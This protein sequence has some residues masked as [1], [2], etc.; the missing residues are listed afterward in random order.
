MASFLTVNFNSSFFIENLL[1]SIP[2]TWKES[3]EI[4]IVDNSRNLSLKNY[5]DLKIIEGTGTT[6]FE[7]IE[8][9]IKESSNE[10]IIFSDS[11]CILLDCNLL[12]QLENFLEK[13]V[14]MIQCEGNQFKP[15]H[16]CF[17]CLKKSV[18]EE[19]K[20]S[21]MSKG[22]KKEPEDWKKIFSNFKKNNLNNEFK[23]KVYFDVGVECAYKLLRN[24][25]KVLSIP[26]ICPS[27]E[28]YEFF[29]NKK[30]SFSNLGW[31]FGFEKPQVWHIVYGSSKKRYLKKNSEEIWNQKKEV[32]NFVLEKILNIH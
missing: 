13:E 10:N 1:S 20:L 26:R 17:G 14:A 16:P 18:F 22:L 25:K 24:N 19:N 27:K 21:F 11:D 4:I 31:W 15:F 3:N 8:Q 30:M 5:E 7:G 29:E 12:N 9:G 23:D 2:K 6:H 32:I 28:I